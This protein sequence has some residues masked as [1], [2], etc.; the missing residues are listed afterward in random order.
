MN[1]KPCVVLLALALTNNYIVIS[2][3][4]I[5][6]MKPYILFVDQVKAKTFLRAPTNSQTTLLQMLL[7]P[8]RSPK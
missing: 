7:A 4:Y 5:Y 6:S 3:K 8:Q 2:T 1:E